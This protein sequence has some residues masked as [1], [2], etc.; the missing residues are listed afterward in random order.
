MK[1]FLSTRCKDEPSRFIGIII[2]VVMRFEVRSCPPA[3]GGSLC[4]YYGNEDTNILRQILAGFT[5]F[6]IQNTPCAVESKLFPLKNEH[7]NLLKCDQV[8]CTEAV[9]EP[10]YHQFVF[11]EDQC[12][13]NKKVFICSKEELP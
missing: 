11:V 1:D 2:D 10:H 8:E 3:S 7:C 9:P 6:S 5:P 12:T 13:W 4:K